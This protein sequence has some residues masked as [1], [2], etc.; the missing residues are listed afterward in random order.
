MHQGRIAPLRR[1]AFTTIEVAG[2][3]TQPIAAGLLKPASV[4]DMGQVARG[5]EPK[6]GASDEIT[7]F[8]SGG[9]GH[10]DL[11]TAWAVYKAFKA[12]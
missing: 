7:W 5:E 8:K 9:G 4:I 10:E 6:R 11:A 2:D 3:L 1:C 12:E